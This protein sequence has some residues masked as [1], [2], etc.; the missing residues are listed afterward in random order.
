M[1]KSKNTRHQIHL[2]LFHIVVAFLL[3]CFTGCFEITE[4]ISLNADGSGSFNLMINAS[5]SKDNLRNYMKVGEADGKKIPSQMEINQNLLKMKF[6]LEGIQGIQNVKLEKDFENFIF[7]LSGEFDQLEKLNL[8]I[9]Q[10]S[11][12]FNTSNYTIDHKDN[13]KFIP[14]EVVRLF[15]YPIDPDFYNNA[16]TTVQYILDTAR[17]TSIIRL[18]QKIKSFSNK[19]AILS[20]SGRAVMLKASLAE[21]TKSEKSL[22]NKISY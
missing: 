20:P 2:Q 13:F 12:S 1:S 16:R 3:I 8:G 17:V 18:Q 15:N 11:E 9:V 6:I 14:G 22:E 4:D 10:L 7:K 19:K 5:E 21:L